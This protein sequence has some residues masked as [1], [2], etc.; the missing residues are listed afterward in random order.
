MKPYPLKL[1]PIF[2]ERIWG[3]RKLG[4]LFK[5]DIPEGKK[6]G[7]SWEIADLPHDKSEIVNGELAGMSIRQAV[8]RYPGQIMGNEFFEGGFPLLIKIL[9]AND[10]LSVQVHPDEQACQRMGTGDPKTECWYIIEAEPEAVIYKGLKDGVTKKHFIDAVKMGTVD[11]MLKK[12]EVRPGECHFLPAGTAHALGAGVLLFEI[13][14]PSD[15][16]YRIFDWNR[17]DDQGKPRQLHIDEALE[18]MHF[19]SSKD[20]LTTTTVGR[21][22]D[23][24]YFKVDKGHQ[25]KSCEVLLSPGNMKVLLF[26]TGFGT[27][28]GTDGQGVDFDSGDSIIV[29]A[30]YEGVI[31]F[32]DDCQYLTVTQ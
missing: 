3:G 18:S 17:V 16:T 29:P 24:E 12:I 10:V 11:T 9:D 20:N 30:D 21:L 15:T 32:A 6:I 13:Q 2:K 7:E 25:A 4:T 31:R 23:S 14:L 5:K 1:K 27:F 28:S 26:I 19:D 8:N 22:V